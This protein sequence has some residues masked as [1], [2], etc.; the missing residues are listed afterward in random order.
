MVQD[1]SEIFQGLISEIELLALETWKTFLHEFG[2]RRRRK[3]FL[4]EF[5]NIDELEV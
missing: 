5:R 4:Y 2:N 3:T 1:I